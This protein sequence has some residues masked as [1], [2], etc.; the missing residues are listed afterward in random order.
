M[1]RRARELLDDAAALSRDVERGVFCQSAALSCSGKLLQTWG[2][3]LR[4]TAATWGF[5]CGKLLRTWGFFGVNM[6]TMNYVIT[7]FSLATHSVLISRVTHDELLFRK[8]QR[9]GGGKRLWV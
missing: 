9:R 7:T 4:K 8:L 6:T 1:H 3:F 2:V 5:F